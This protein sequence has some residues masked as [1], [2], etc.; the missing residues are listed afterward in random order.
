M[1][2]KLSKFADDTKL[3]GEVDSRGGGDQIQESIDT[4]I[5]WAKDWQ[6]EF[7]LSKCK[8][9]GMG[10]NNENRDYRIQ[11]VIL[12]RVTQE[13]DL[14]VV[15]DMGGKQVAQCQAAKGKTN[16][17]LGCIR[18][19]VIFKSKEVVLTLCRNLV[20]ATSRLLCAV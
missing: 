19:G 4:C 20:R 18:R 8:V 9:L 5:D 2:S 11:G 13:K 1:K 6:M 7:N 3:G 17:V 10:K 15:I 12:E 16:R 14:V